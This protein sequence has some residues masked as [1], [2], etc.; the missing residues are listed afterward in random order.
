VPKKTRSRAVDP[1]A[2]RQRALD[3][4]IKHTIKVEYCTGELIAEATRGSAY[5]FST[6]EYGIKRDL[7]Y[8]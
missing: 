4:D 1:R 6:A 8:R 5:G 7:A 3:K 2:V